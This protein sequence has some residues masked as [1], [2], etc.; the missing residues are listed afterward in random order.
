MRI[1]LT[2]AKTALPFSEAQKDDAALRKACRE[3]ESLLT[4]QMLQKMRDS[5]PKSDL[6]GSREKEEIFQS[7]LDEEMAKHIAHTGALGLGDAIYA[8]LKA[9]NIAKVPADS[10]DR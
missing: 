9:R 5:V 3:F 6:F 2:A 4:A 8:Q 1:D 7:M 10:V